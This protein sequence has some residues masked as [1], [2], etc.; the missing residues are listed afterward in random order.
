M[1]ILYINLINAKL[2]KNAQ[3]VEKIE[4][5]IRNNKSKPEL[6]DSEFIND[7]ISKA[8][9]DLTDTINN[10]SGDMNSKFAKIEEYNSKIFNI[11]ENMKDNIFLKKHDININSIKVLNIAKNVSFYKQYVNIDKD[12]MFYD[13]FKEEVYKFIFLQIESQNFR[14][15]QKFQMNI[16]KTFNS[17]LSDIEILDLIYFYNMIYIFYNETKSNNLNNLLEKI[18]SSHNVP[19]ILTNKNKLYNY[20]KEN[21]EIFNILL[22][23]IVPSDKSYGLLYIN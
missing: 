18:I 1:D 14:Y 8:K 6:Y 20:F 23:N 22:Q 21:I 16:L 11:Y 3:E 17:K 19:D 12:T 13:I 2:N 9:S 10:I 15:N 5:L 4:E 7:N